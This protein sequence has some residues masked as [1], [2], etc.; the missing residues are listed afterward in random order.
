MIKLVFT[1]LSFYFVHA[2]L[3]KVVGEVERINTLRETLV[4]G[5]TSQAVDQTLFKAV[6]APVGKEAK[7][8]ASTNGWSFRQISHKPRNPIHKAASFEAKMIQRFLK[9]KELQSLWLK[10]QGKSH[11]FRRIVVQEKCLSCH[12]PKN[13]R[14]DFIKNKYPKDK[15]FGFKLGDL[16]GLYH[17]SF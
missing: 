15:A 16:R 2:D 10:H 1:I 7:Q 13:K 4:S 6:C 11:Y 5:V 14:P 9:E 8:V 12:G 3:S 17:V